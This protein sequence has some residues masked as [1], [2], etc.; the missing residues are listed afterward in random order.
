MAGNIN[1]APRMARKSIVKDL[2]GNIID[3]IDEERG[4]YIIR[5]GQIVNH[6]RYNE[7]VQKEI[8]RK[9][10]IEAQL[11]P[12]SNPN[13]PD[14]TVTAK[15]AIKQQSKVEE[16]EERLNKQDDKLDKQNDKLDKILKALQK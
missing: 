12:V 14:R 6:E 3:L 8:D 13:T 15:E 1:I 4:G 16:L 10:S 7:M 9:K 11:N 2:R 5:R